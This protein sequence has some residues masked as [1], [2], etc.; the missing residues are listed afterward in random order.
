M[1]RDVFPGQICRYIAGKFLSASL[2]HAGFRVCDTCYL[3]DDGSSYLFMDRE[4]EIKRT[5]FLKREKRW[6]DLRTSGQ[7]SLQRLCYNDVSG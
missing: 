7:E 3:S 2:L 5:G 1:V 6:Q 4:E